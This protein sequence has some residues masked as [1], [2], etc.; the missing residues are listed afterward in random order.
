M[1]ARPKK[2]EK[3]KKKEERRFDHV[4]RTTL[5]RSLDREITLLKDTPGLI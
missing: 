3:K 5:S 2:T 1:A 4:N